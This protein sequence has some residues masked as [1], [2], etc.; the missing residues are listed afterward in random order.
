[1]SWFIL[2]LVDTRVVSSPTMAMPILWCVANEI[3]DSENAYSKLTIHFPTTNIYPYYIVTKLALDYSRL[4]SILELVGLG[5]QIFLIKSRLE[6]CSTT[7][8]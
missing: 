7:Y 5:R 3:S 1:M 4:V 2:E 8:K 6:K